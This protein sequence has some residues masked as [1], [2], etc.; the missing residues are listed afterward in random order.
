VLLAFATS[1]LIVY[2]L[3]RLSKMIIVPGPFWHHGGIQ[4]VLTQGAGLQF[5]RVAQD[6]YSSAEISLAGFFP[7]YPGVV[8]AFA[9]VVR[10]HAL[11]ALVISNICLLIAGILL[12]ELLELDYPDRRISR[13]AVMMLMFSPA[14]FFFSSAYSES[15]FLILALAAFLAAR[16]N[17]WLL[18]SVA[19]MCLG[20]TSP[21]GVLI[22]I[23]LAWEYLGASATGSVNRRALFLALIPMG[24]G[25]FLLY[26]HIKFGNALAPFTSSELWRGADISPA[27]MSSP[28]LSP[29]DS[30]ADTRSLSPFY[31]YF[32]AVILAS[33]IALFALG[34]VMKVRRSY[35]VYAALLIL[36]FALAKDLP[37]IARHLAV[38]FPLYVA[39]A[40]LAVRFAWAYELAFVSSVAVMGFCTILAATGHWMR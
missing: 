14:A 10:S 19:G 2:W 1:R 21:V 40:L 38:V 28:A 32:T 11:A 16:R 3:I 9:F 13:A 8:H 37:S 33:G 15:T 35:L 17:R 6:G 12:K 31:R 26:A 4:S 34:A 23:P 29:T 20:I 39:L 25:V 30:L 18:A 7:F 22:L 24:C 36:V 5:L 27:E